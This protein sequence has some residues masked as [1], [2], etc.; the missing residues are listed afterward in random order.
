MLKDVY[1]PGIASELF[2]YWVRYRA[3]IIS[4][5]IQKEKKVFED[6]EKWLQSEGRLS[7]FVDVDGRI[8]KVH[9]NAFRPAREDELG[10]Q[11]LVPPD[12]LKRFLKN[13]A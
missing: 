5:N 9:A 1:G 11:V 7:A 10:V 8:F 2:P 12:W 4:L 6:I 3:A 13:S